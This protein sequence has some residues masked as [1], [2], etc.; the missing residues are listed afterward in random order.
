MRISEFQKIA[1]RPTELVRG[2]IFKGHVILLA[3]F[4]GTIKSWIMEDLAISV[5]SGKPSLFGVVEEQGHVILIDEETE[6][7]ILGNRLHRLANG[8]GV[9]LEDLPLTIHSL[10]GF[11]LDNDYWIQ[12]ITEEIRKEKAIMTIIDNL[13]STLGKFRENSSDDIGKARDGWNKLKASGSTV[14]IVHHFG[15]V[16]EKDE[17]SFTAA[18]RGSTKVLDSADTAFSIRN[19][20]WPRIVK[21]EKARHKLDCPKEFAIGFEEGDDWIRL[22][23][24][25][26]PVPELTRLEKLIMP[27]FDED[28]RELYIWDVHKALGGEGEVTDVRKALHH[29]E[30]LK[31]IK[32]GIEAHGR[33]KYKKFEDGLY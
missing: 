21:L 7:D 28:L 23:I 10:D 29:L 15:K 14:P 11:R 6:S 8:K 4:W 2:T 26:I 22:M 1:K 33:Y 25:D 31:L 9:V 3:G 18:L 12:V 13:S 16:G 32:H 24:V 17:A 27:L 19:H 5:A 30:K 20:D